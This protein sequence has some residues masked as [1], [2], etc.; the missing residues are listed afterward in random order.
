MPSARRNKR[1]GGQASRR[2]PRV[3]RIRFPFLARRQRVTAHD[4]KQQRQRHNQK[5][6]LLI[7]G[8]RKHQ[9]C[10]EKSPHENLPQKRL[11]PFRLRLARRPSRA[12]R[13]P[14]P[15]HA[16]AKCQV[17][18]SSFARQVCFFQA[19]QAQTENKHPQHEERKSEAAGEQSHPRRQ[20][21]ISQIQGITNVAT[22]SVREH[23]LRVQVRVAPISQKR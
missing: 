6:R 8:D 14:Q 15:R 23:L 18:F 13:R 19:N 22:R 12:E 7:D 17:T 21:K 1:R 5:E 2:S 4:I 11:P 10:H 9:Y 20:K 16:A 3:P